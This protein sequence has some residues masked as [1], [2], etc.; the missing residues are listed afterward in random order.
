MLLIEELLLPNGKKVSLKI[1]SGKSYGLTGPNGSG[2]S[3]LLKSLAHLLPVTFKTFEYNSKNVL[4]LSPEAYRSSVLYLPSV[5]VVSD[6][7]SVENYLAAPFKLGIYKS[8]QSNFPI[9]NFIE[10]YGLSGKSMGHLSSGQKQVLSFLRALTLKAD[11]LL[12]DE[13]TSHLDPFMT[14]E[15]EAQLLEWKNADSARSFVLVSHQEEQ[16]RRLAGNK[17]PL[18]SLILN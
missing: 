7:L 5:P 8:H 10:R 15:L 1:E 6:P 18:E 3:L 17:L 9:H 13:P 14:Q 16:V 2:K 4:N 11:C 12:L